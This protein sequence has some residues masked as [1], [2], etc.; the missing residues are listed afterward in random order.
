[1][2]IADI[3]STAFRMSRADIAAARKVASAFAD[4]GSMPPMKMVE[5]MAVIED[6]TFLPGEFAT[7]A[8]IVLNTF[9]SGIAEG[10]LNED[11]FT[12]KQEDLIESFRIA[13]SWKDVLASFLP[14]KERVREIQPI[15]H[16][17]IG[18]IG[19]AINA[20]DHF[21]TWK[22]RAGNVSSSIITR[23]IAGVGGYVFEFITQ[24]PTAIMNLCDALTGIF[25]GF[26]VTATFSAPSNVGDATHTSAVEHI[27]REDSD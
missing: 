25:R 22:N 12:E 21:P 17:V 13:Q 23:Q 19:K 4:I 11:G 3:T 27:P 14:H 9:Q 6:T 18:V 16:H 20:H 1:M 2:N 24:N 7:Y 15:L 8:D 26:S 10:M 5:A